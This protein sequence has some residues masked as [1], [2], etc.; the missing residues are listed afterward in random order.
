M[1]GTLIFRVS[2]SLS[3]KSSTP[4]TALPP[5]LQ[6]AASETRTLLNTAR[7]ACVLAGT[8]GSDDVE[9]A[10]ARAL[11]KIALERY[12]TLVARGSP[13]VQLSPMGGKIE[14]ERDDEG[15]CNWKERVEDR[16]DVMKALGGDAH[17]L[18][19]AIFESNRQ[20]IWFGWRG[21]F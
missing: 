12:V 16:N 10:Q 11:T 1:S 19:V 3:T 2:R 7:D 20:R 15:G 21:W 9:R 8:E 6:R 5:A 18:R 17:S 14:G 13:P 4:V